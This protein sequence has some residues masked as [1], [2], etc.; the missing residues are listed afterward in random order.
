MH[1]HFM[2]LSFISNLVLSLW[3]PQHHAS[4]VASRHVPRP[5]VEQGSPQPPL[6]SFCAASLALSLPARSILR[7]VAASHAGPLE[8]GDD[9][10]AWDAVPVTGATAYL[11]S[12]DLPRLHVENGRGA[13][14]ERVELSL[15]A[16]C[17]VQDPVAGAEGCV[18]TGDKTH[19]IPE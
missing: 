6:P 15:D 16:A 1:E 11:E 12:G 2:F 14:G 19:S 7:G 5:Q 17:F 18:D 4:G 9:A 3:M 10:G 8:T 13:E